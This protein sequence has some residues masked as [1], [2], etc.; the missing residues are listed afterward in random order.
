MNECDILVVGGGPAG[1]S[2]IR[3]AKLGADVVLIDDGLKLG[4]QL[5]KQTHKFFGSAEQFAGM[6]GVDIANKLVSELY[7]S[8]TKVLPGATVLGIYEDGVVNYSKDN[9]V[10]EIK[11]KRTIVA[12]GAK[13]KN[14]LFENNDLPGVYGAGA[15]QTLVNV[16]GIKVGN[17]VLMIGAG[18]IGLIVTYQLMQAGIHVQAII[19]AT[20]HVGGYDVHARKVKRLGIPIIFKHSIKRV[21][22]Y[23]SVEEAIVVKLDDRFNPIPGT[24]KK[25]R[26]D[27]V[28]IAVGL[29]PL[30]ELL[31]QAGCEM[32]YIPELGGYVPVRDED[33]RTSR[34]DIFVAGDV[35]GIEEATSAMLEGTIAGTEAARSLGYPVEDDELEKAKSYLNQLRAGPTGKKIRIGLEKLLGKRHSFET[36]ATIHKPSKS[37]M[38][39][40]KRVPVVECFQEIPCN[41]CEASCPFDAITI[42]KDINARPSVDYS[43][44]TGCGICALKCPGLAIFMITEDY[45]DS[46]SLLEIPYEML[47][48]PRPGDIADGIDRDGNFV[49]EVKVLGVI[50]GKDK[51]NLVRIIIPKEYADRVRSVRVKEYKNDKIVCRCE[52]VTEKEIVE[53]I[54][55]GY[56][57]FDEL[58]RLLRV[59]MGPCGGKNCREE[60]LKIIARE[61][62]KSVE[63]LEVGT[64]RP[65]TKPTPFSAFKNE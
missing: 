57:S 31:W 60:V 18:N 13:E 63:E 20:D 30:A 15:V 36:N 37:T 4:G 26:V 35:A 46:E 7:E 39:K 56:T 55:R 44:C 47:P 2:A 65:P 49:C 24:E 33:M 11:P 53:A 29:S 23:N 10:R 48:I 21:D 22:G 25:F 64:Y 3:S 1:I 27:T 58:K 16:Y 50:K 43:K 9:V 34:E 41:P 14:L 59:G 54:R 45:S 5:I 28:C 12:T 8:G 52:D 62:G 40:N 51:T 32:K 19:E 6:R 17:E 38:P 42:G 61:T